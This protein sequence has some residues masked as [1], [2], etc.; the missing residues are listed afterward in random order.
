[1]AKKQVYHAQSKHIDVQHH[2]IR[3]WLNSEEIILKKVHREENAA[4]MLTKVITMEKFI[5]YLDLLHAAST[6]IEVE[7]LQHGGATRT[8]K[9]YAMGSSAK[10]EFVSLCV[11]P[12]PSQMQER[13]ALTN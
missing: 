4:G 8:P 12:L 10:V 11:S 5:H 1:M 7:R 6:L 9:A 3:E 13:G 2:K